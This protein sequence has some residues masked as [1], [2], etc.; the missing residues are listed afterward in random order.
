MS[1]LVTIQTEIRDA[2]AIRAAQRRLGWEVGA[3]WQTIKF[4]SGQAEGWAINAPGWRY[5]IVATADGTLHYDNYN[6]R[7]GNQKHLDA[8]RQAYA[9]EKSKL[10]AR[11]KGYSVTE[12]SLPNGDVKLEVAVP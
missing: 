9:V 8:F 3:N 4:Y 7:W 5:P 10:E 12:K 2:N 1:H 6:G 11:R